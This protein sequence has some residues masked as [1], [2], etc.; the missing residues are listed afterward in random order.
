MKLFKLVF[1][2]AALAVFPA[3]AQEVT[4]SS[5]EIIEALLPMDAA[6]RR[7]KGARSLVGEPGEEERQ[8]R[9]VK[10]VGGEDVPFIDLRVAFEYD[11]DRLSNDSMLTLQR[12]AAAL[13]NEQLQGSKF[14]IVGH[15]DA[16]GSVEYNQDLSER[17]ARSVVQYLVEHKHI[18]ADR[19]EVAA[20]GKSELIEGIDPADERNRR[21]EIQNIGKAE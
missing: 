13:S 10:V 14:R 1:L 17:R 9:G 2:G 5:D 15:T 4:P 7:V 3:Q 11:S 16:R 8:G 6:G 12:L 20:R 19:V 21:V 18:T